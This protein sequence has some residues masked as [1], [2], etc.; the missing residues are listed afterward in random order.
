VKDLLG[1]KDLRMTVKYCHLTPENLSEAV[2]VL[3]DRESGYVLAT[4]EKEKRA[5]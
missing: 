2:K 5:S 4:F 3:D 1:H